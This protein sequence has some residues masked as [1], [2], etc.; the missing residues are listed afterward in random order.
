MKKVSLIFALILIAGVGFYSC[1]KTSLIEETVNEPLNQEPLFVEPSEEIINGELFIDG[2]SQKE[3]ITDFDLENAK[4]IDGRLAFDNHEAL[5]K[6]INKLAEYNT[7][8]V[9]AWGEKIG[10]TS[11]FAELTRIEERPVS[12]MQTELDKG[13]MLNDHFHI[14]KSGEL[15]LS[16][17]TILMSRLYNTQGL[18]QVGNFV[19]TIMPGLTVWVEAK[20]TSKLIEAL[21]NQYIPNNDKDF[22]VGENT[23]FNNNKNWIALENCPK[24]FTWVG[25]LHQ[26]KNPS[27]NRRI[28]IRNSYYR[29]MTPTPGNLWTISGEY[30][31]ETVSKKSSWNKYKTNHYLNIDIRARRISPSSTQPITSHQKS[32]HD[33]NTKY[34]F[35]S[36]SLSGFSGVDN[37]FAGLFKIRL[38]ETKPGG[39]G[40]WD[41]GTSASHQGMGGRYGRHQCN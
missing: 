31:I 39:A 36:L 13:D 7:E 35:I 2:V 21:K 32:E 23:I 19:G 18:V 30:R 29:I 27:Q 9:I 20:H 8:S 14:T 11:L 28:E 16:K 38:V 3:V 34:G 26:Y 24:D 6:G 17:H 33:N 15:E 5:V 4:V 25:P 12:E 37:A 22:L 41:P 40:W 1:E 10:F